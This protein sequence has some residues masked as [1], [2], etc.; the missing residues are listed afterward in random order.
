MAI[1]RVLLAAFVV[2]GLGG[3]GAG[4]AAERR[5]PLRIG[6]YSTVDGSVGFV[7]DRLGTPAKLRFDGSEEIFALTPR[8]ASRDSVWMVRDDGRYVLGVSPEGEISLYP[9]FESRP[10]V[11][12][13]TNGRDIDVVRDDVADALAIAP[14]TRSAAYGAAIALGEELTRASTASIGVVVEAKQLDDASSAW[15]AVADALKMA[16]IAF[17]DVLAD[18]LGRRAVASD[19]DR[20]VIRDGGHAAVTLADRALTIEINAATPVAG[21]PSSGRIK[22]AMGDLLVLP[23]PDGAPQSLRIRQL[24]VHGEERLIEH[25]DSTNK[26]CDTNLAARLDWSDVSTADIIKWDLAGYCNSSALGGIRQVCADKVGKDAVKMRIKRVTCGFA[27][28]RAISLDD[29]GTLTY[30][31]NFHSADVDFVFEYLQNHL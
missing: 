1:P 21:R 2:V 20:I 13:S 14:A 29:G 18:P 22:A 9:S 26:I 6:H 15:S 31:T 17:K 23:G 7:F 27:A 10:T 3:Y 25:A 11:P 8:P 30:K 24:E 12:Y 19:L 5:P 16:G 4:V 28:Q